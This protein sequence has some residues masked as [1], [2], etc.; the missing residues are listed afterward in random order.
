MAMG[1]R[2]DSTRRH[3]LRFHATCTNPCC[4]LSHSHLSVN[5]QSTANQPLINQAR[6]ATAPL[7]HGV[8]QQRHW[9]ATLARM[10]AQPGPDLDELAAIESHINQGVSLPLVSSPSSVA[11]TNTP[12]VQ[13][14]ASEVRTPLREYMQFGA[15]IQ[16]PADAHLDDNGIRIQPLHVIIKAGKKPRL[17]ID[18]SRNFDDHLQHEYFTCSCVD[19]AVEASHAGCW[20]GKLDL[21]NCFSS[22]PLHPSVRKYFCFRFEGELYPISSLTCRSA[23]ALPLASAR[24]CCRSFTLLSL[25]SAS[26]ASATSTTSSSSARPRKTWHDICFSLSRPSVS[27]ASSSTRTRRRDQPS[28]CPSSA[29]NSTRSIRLC[30]ALPS[31]WRRSSQHCYAPSSAPPASHQSQGDMLHH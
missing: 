23:S 30:R 31:A 2:D 29:S 20:Y 13:Q 7:V 18:L 17:V 10:R 4:H 22:F 19:D 14:H 12:T 26:A 1:R 16:L 8:E 3:G 5:C 27:S 24:S 21:S 28:R 15:V 25:S 9:L 11:Y 6:H